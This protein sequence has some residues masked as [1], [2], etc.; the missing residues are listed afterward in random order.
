MKTACSPSAEKLQSLS[1]RISRLSRDVEVL[2]EHALP[3]ETN[4]EERVLNADQR[5]VLG[6]LE[7]MKKKF[8][9]IMSQFAVAPDG[10]RHHF[11]AVQLRFEKILERYQNSSNSSHK[12]Q[13]NNPAGKLN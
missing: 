2:V 7:E 4:G 3:S 9:T 11:A 8:E 13:D 5:H 6:R 1:I 10:D 12:P